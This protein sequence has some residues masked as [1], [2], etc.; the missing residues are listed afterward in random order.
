M[1]TIVDESDSQLAGITSN[2]ALNTVDDAAAA[3]VAQVEGQQENDDNFKLK[4][5]D[6]HGLANGA[7]VEASMVEIRPDLA[8]DI[9]KEETEMPIGP[10]DVEITDKLLGYLEEDTF[11][12]DITERQLRNR[13][14][15]HFG[16]PLKDKKS[17]IRDKVWTLPFQTSVCPQDGFGSLPLCSHVQYMSY[18]LGLTHSACTI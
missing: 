14:E 5:A 7:E 1:E 4:K 17:I 8:E 6:V 9:K 13:L 11:T 16:V 15:Q 3:E 10:T 12:M 2:E 18:P